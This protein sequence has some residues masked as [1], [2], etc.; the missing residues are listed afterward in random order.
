MMSVVPLE[1]CW[2]FNTLWNNKFYYKAA[3]CWYFYWV[4]HDARIHEYHHHIVLKWWNFSGNQQH[5]FEDNSTWETPSLDVICWTNVVCLIDLLCWR[6]RRTPECWTPALKWS[7]CPKDSITLLPCR[8]RQQDSLKCWYLY[9]NLHYIPAD[10]FFY[11]I[12]VLWKIK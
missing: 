4:I 1:T 7:R 10:G 8:W 9:T 3:S 5:Q 2:A 12:T 11:F 6:D